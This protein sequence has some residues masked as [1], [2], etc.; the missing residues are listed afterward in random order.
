MK[1]FARKEEEQCRSLTL[2]ICRQDD[3]RR[4]IYQSNQTS[5]LQAEKKSQGR[6]EPDHFRK[7]QYFRRGGPWRSAYVRDIVKRL[8]G[9]N[10][11]LLPPLSGKVSGRS[12]RPIRSRR[13]QSQKGIGRESA[14]PLRSTIR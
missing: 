5:G 14:D 10:I 12:I 7:P 1:R 6:S 2:S 11:A 8:P 4:R 9:D 13:N 3:H